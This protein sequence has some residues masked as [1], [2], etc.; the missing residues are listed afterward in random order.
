MSLEPQLGGG[1]APCS[2]PFSVKKEASLNYVHCSVA[3]PK[4]RHMQAAPRDH[5]R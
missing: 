1:F 2:F 3:L 4:L 5:E